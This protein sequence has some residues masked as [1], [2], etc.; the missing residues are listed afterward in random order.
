MHVHAYVRAAFVHGSRFSLQTK[1]SGSFAAALQKRC[2]QP[3]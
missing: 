3:R 2:A 1:Q